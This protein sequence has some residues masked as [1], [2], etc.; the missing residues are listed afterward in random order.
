MK[1]DRLG[2]TIGSF[3]SNYLWFASVLLSIAYLYL[4]DYDG[5]PNE[6]ND[7]DGVTFSAVDIY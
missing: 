2:E 1:Q 4:W 6:I 3:T 5:N 7:P